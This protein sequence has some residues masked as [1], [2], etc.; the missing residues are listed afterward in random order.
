MFARSP[1][2]GQG[3]VAGFPPGQDCIKVGLSASYHEE[4][5]GRVSEFMTQEVLVI[6]AEA[7]LMD[8]A[9]L[10]VNRPFRC[11]PVVN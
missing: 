3:K 6:E 1:R 10:F 4:R 8:A 5:G 7:S 9:E 2:T 11:Y